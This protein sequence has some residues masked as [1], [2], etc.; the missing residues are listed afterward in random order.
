MTLL[1]DHRT[2]AKGSD[3]SERTKR[4]TFMSVSFLESLVP[5]FATKKRPGS[6]AGLPGLLH[7]RV[8]LCN[9]TVLCLYQ[10]RDGAWSGTTFMTSENSTGGL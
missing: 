7:K 9:E 2:M 3:A 4:N 6:P 8:V 1:K 5:W 10:Y